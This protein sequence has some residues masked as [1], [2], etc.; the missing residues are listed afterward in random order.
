MAEDNGKSSRQTT[1]RQPFRTAT[2][3]SYGHAICVIVGLWLVLCLATLNYNGAF[4]DEGIYITAGL[5]T[6]EGYGHS[7]NYLSW[8][9]GSLLWPVLAA[10]GYNAAGLAGA[11][12]VAVG[13]SAVA[14]IS[15]TLA[16]RNLFG[17]KASF[18]TALTFAVNGPFIGM[19]RLGVYDAL[20]LAGVAVSLWAITELKRWDSRIW[21]GVA[22]VAYTVSLFAKYPMGLMLFPLLGILLSLRKEKGIADVV[23]FGFMSTALVLAFFLPVRGQ[24]GSFLSWRLENKPEFGVGLAVIGF[25]ILYL[26]AAP[27]LLALGGWFLARDRRDLAS[28]LLFSLLLWPTYH[29]L[30]KDP[31]S[32]NKHLVFGY[33][34][35]YP[36]VGLVLSRLW[37][38]VQPRLFLRRGAVI[39]I[40]LVL[41]GLGVVQVGQTDLAWPDV[42][43]PAGYLVEHVQ[44]GE[45]LLINESWPYTL[46]LYDAGRI[47]SPWDVFDVYRVT[48]GESEIDLCEYDWFVDSQ[49]SYRWPE[50][51]VETIDQCG[52]F[53]PV[54]A[55]AGTV[56]GASSDLTYVTYSVQ[57]T[58]WQNTSKR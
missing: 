53:E 28:I 11:R 6:L 15:G 40:V 32:T 38:D 24:I 27:A 46:H 36:L 17:P 55:G 57:T 26:S 9:G 30:L 45:K 4:F 56:V 51:I 21:L 49:G 41:A 42:R 7:D 50:A 37:G 48:H 58:I 52:T 16:T 39:L 20:A 3:N 5:R 2:S 19:A 10:L 1:T 13:V 18:W 43:Q 47:E 22:A 8:F 14:L 44:P 29:L 54:F 25:V 12:A 23:M 34:F 31:T 35:A 33:L